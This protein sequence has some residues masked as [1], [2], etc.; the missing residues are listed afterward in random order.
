MDIVSTACT[1]R[2]HSM[3]R[4]TSWCAVPGV[5]WT[6]RRRS[7]V[8]T[9]ALLV[10]VVAHDLDIVLV[11]VVTIVVATAE[12]VGLLVVV[13]TVVAAA[14]GVVVVAKRSDTSRIPTRPVASVFFTRTV[15][16][17]LMSNLV[18]RSW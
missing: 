17:R 15:I 9:K 14:V 6:R 18:K 5:E 16:R 12:V 10:N 3:P 11:A 13:V 1:L 4:G 2:M 8:A 7:D